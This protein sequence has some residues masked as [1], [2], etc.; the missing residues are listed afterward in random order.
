M[1]FFCHTFD[2]SDS[3]AIRLVDTRPNY[4]SFALNLSLIIALISHRLNALPQS[5]IGNEVALV[6]PT[7]QLCGTFQKSRNFFP[8]SDCYLFCLSRRIRRLLL[9]LCLYNRSDNYQA[10]ILQRRKESIIS[11]CP[12]LTCPWISKE[13]SVGN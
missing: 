9:N 4:A 11:F 13:V 3:P 12:I 7:L 5:L 8:F 1:S 6:K 10:T 2:S